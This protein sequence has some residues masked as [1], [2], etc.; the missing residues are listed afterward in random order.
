MRSEN[1]FTLIEL[2]VSML[3]AIV[4]AG[5][6]F[7]ILEIS[8]RQDARITDGVQSDQLGRITMTNITEELHSA[9][10]GA[11]TGGYSAIQKPTTAPTS[12]LGETGPTNLWFIS[13][14][15]TT[16]SATAELKEVIEHD[17][18]WT[19]TG[20]SNTGLKLGKLTDYAFAGTGT[21]GAW[22]FPS[23]TTTNAKA[24]VIAENVM[25]VESKPI[26]QYFAYY[27]NQSES[28]YGQL[29]ASAL[30]TPL[31]S[32]AAATNFAGGVAQVTINFAQAPADK[33]TQLDRVVNLSNSVVLR[34]SP[35]SIA[36]GVSPCS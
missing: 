23:L 2:L 9:C 22:T 25:Q 36:S 24:R 30:T 10:T 16:S 29:E 27:D 11:G 20:L 19:E 21:V 8:T 13:T 14:Y 32:E 3:T 17:I 35:T 5:A 34:F 6:L 18:N 28:D 1:G 12:P 7:A 15:G 33:N 26:F 4:V 31:S